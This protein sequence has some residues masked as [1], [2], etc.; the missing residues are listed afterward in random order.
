MS[1]TKIILTGAQGT[2]KTTLLNM[3]N[4]P[5][6]TEVVRRLHREK[7]IKVNEMG[8]DEGQRLIWDTYKELFK[9]NEFISDRGLTDVLAYTEYGFRE[10]KVSERIYRELRDEF[11]EF[12]KNNSDII[13]VYLPIEFD[14]PEDGFRSVDKEFQK[15]IDTIIREILENSRMNYLTV[16]GSVEE[17]AA[18]VIDYLKRLNIPNFES[19]LGWDK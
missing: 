19:A 8:D 15:E 2:G 1:K 4:M 7:G 9:Q 17:R 12:I 5:K 3:F 13:Y 18:Q 6:I 14:I 16:C 11:D 10:G